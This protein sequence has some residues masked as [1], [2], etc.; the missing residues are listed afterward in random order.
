[1]DVKLTPEL[2]ARIGERVSSGLYATPS[3]VVREGLRLLFE[4]E[5]DR[6]RL[7]Q[8]VGAEVQQGFAQ[9]QLG[10]LVD[11]PAAVERLRSSIAA[12]PSPPAGGGG[13]ASLA[14]VALGDELGKL[15]Q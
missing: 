8:A 9:A 12:A 6:D 4:R 3:E 1:M 11:G 10:E 15:G 13:P 2:E 5:D 7:L 14:V